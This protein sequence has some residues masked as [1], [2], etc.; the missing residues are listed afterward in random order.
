MA[1]VISSDYNYSGGENL[2]EYRAWPF[3][4]NDPHI[5]GI[6][7]GAR[8]RQ[9]NVFSNFGQEDVSEHS[10]IGY[11]EIANFN[12]AVDPNELPAAEVEYKQRNFLDKLF[13]LFGKAS[14]VYT[15][16]KYGDREERPV[17]FDVTAGRDDEQR[18]L[19]IALIGGALVAGM[20]LL[21]AM[22]K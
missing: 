14:E 21:S 3:A 8:T 17:E 9:E 7:A 18:I 12:P 10:F 13:G 1:I 6:S 20:L 16:V 19:R 22:K 2:E 15:E 11:D 5:G 4:V